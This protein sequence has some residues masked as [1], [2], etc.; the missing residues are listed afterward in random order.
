MFL[1]LKQACSF[2]LFLFRAAYLEGIECMVERE[3][4][5][6]KAI[7]L[8]NSTHKYESNSNK[9]AALGLVIITWF[10]S[11]LCIHIHAFYPL[12]ANEMV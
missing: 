12:K 11:Y 9:H 1:Y 6:N 10:I 8:L 7:Y 3:F 5:Y 4:T 2:V